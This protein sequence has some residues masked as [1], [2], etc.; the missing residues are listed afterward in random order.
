MI[1]EVFYEESSLLPFNELFTLPCGMIELTIS[2]RKKVRFLVI[3]YESVYK[4]IFR[5]SFL[6]KFEAVASPVH[7]KM[8]YHNNAG[9]LICF[10]DDLHGD[11]LSHKSILKN[12]PPPRDD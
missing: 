6:T 7:L 12:P 11:Q 4:A 9:K 3:P 1:F 10:S 8:K 5:I 2:F